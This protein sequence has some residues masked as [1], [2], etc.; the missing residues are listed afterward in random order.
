MAIPANNATNGNV[1]WMGGKNY[2]KCVG[3]TKTKL[4]T[5]VK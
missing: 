2:A 1:G 4:K 3:S 5:H